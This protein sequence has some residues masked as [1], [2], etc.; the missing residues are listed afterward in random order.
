[1]EPSRRSQIETSA[2]EARAKEDAQFQPVIADG[3]SHALPAVLSGVVL[4]YTARHNAPSSIFPSYD[5]DNRFRYA[6]SISRALL[7]AELLAGRT[8]PIKLGPHPEVDAWVESA[9]GENTIV[10]GVAV[11]NDRI[12]A[13]GGKRIDCEPGMA[14]YQFEL[15]RFVLQHGSV[16][17]LTVR[18]PHRIASEKGC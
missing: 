18:P 4:G 15:S 2:R 17:C 12:E 7:Q 16:F 13:M 14:L 8:P 3:V 5:L 6:E 11:P 10:I 9:H 1:M